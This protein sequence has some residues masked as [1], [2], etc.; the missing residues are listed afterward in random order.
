M[1]KQKFII[2]DETDKMLSWKNGL[3]INVWARISLQWKKFFVERK[4]CMWSHGMICWWYVAFWNY[5]NCLYQRLYGFD[6]SSN[7]GASVYVLL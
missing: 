6:F 5:G 3:L 2:W 4:S 7:I 1:T